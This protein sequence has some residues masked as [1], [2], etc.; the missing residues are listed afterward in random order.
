M[1]RLS[2][3]DTIGILGGGQLARMLALAAA[4][5]GLRCHIYAPEGDNPAFQVAAAHTVAAYEDAAALARFAGAVQAITYEFENV[6][7]AAAAQ[8]AALA[9]LRPGATAL[10]VTQDRLTEKRFIHAEGLAT[11][12]FVPVESLAD[13]RAGLDRLGVPAILKTRRFGY[14]GKGQ[15]LIG[16]AAEAEAA[17]AAIGAAPAILEGM[18]RFSRE[19]SVLIARGLDG[20][21]ACFAICENEHRH[22]IL[23]RTTAP[24][25]IQ[26]ALVTDAERLAA[27]L[28]T[29]LD[30]VGVLAVE[31][32]LAH[33][34]HGEAELVVNELAPRV[35]NSGHWT[36]EAC[37]S[38]QF[39]QHIRA[40]AGWPLGNP[41]MRCA[42][43]SMINLIGD[44]VSQWPALLAEPGA[45]LH[46]YGKA[47]TR[48][49]RKMGH[50]TR[51]QNGH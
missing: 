46:L 21:T 9:P 32:F 2:P 48:P 43:A 10:A 47:E 45:A 12:P 37:H 42:S 19:L 31:L 14:D 34:D 39:E 23:H 40:V 38:S 30:Y 20:E 50:V 49:G 51:L 25:R 41:A 35:H 15:V 3:G 44:E 13:L 33:A 29:A 24:A 16:S 11:A 4:P 27:R 7:A 8:L 18:V 6:P 5:L 26:P 1:T 17:F 22:H 28:A 36:I